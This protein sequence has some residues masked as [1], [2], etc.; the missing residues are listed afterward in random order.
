VV[1]SERPQLV[2]EFILLKRKNLDFGW[3][4]MRPT[5]SV[6]LPVFKEEQILPVLYTRFSGVLQALGETYELVFVNDGSCDDSLA[7]LKSLHATDAAVKVVNLSRNFGRQTAITCGLDLASGEAVVIMDTDLQ[8]PPEIITRLVAK[9]RKGY[10]VVYAVRENRQGEN[11]FKRGTA[12]VF[13]RLLR[14]L[15]HVDIPLDTE[16]STC[17]AGGRLTLSSQIGSAVDSCVD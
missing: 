12:A 2:D 14:M 5:I 17:S 6:V 8:D 4:P 3:D 10:D 1:G 7:L 15:V 13:Y 9:W 11:L 16:T